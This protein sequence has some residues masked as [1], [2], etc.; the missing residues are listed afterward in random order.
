MLK[1][2]LQCSCQTQLNVRIRIF[3]R[4]HCSVH[5]K[6]NIRPLNEF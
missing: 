6:G 4:D 5:V 2:S 3:K 1:K